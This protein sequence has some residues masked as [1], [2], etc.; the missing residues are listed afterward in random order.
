MISQTKLIKTIISVAGLLFLII[1]LFPYEA[2]AVYISNY[3]TDVLCILLIGILLGHYIKTYTLNYFDPLILITFIYTFMFFITPAYDIV[4][5][6]YTWFGYSMFQYGVKSGILALAGYLFFYFFYVSKLTN[7]EKR[8]TRNEQKD[9]EEIHDEGKRKMYMV[10]IVIFYVFSFLA[11]VYYLVHSGYAN[12]VYILTLGILGRGGSYGEVMESIG[13]IAMFSYCLPTLVL[14]YWEYAKNKTTTFLLFIPMLMLQV[15][16]GFRFLVVQIAISF[17]AYFFL[18]KNKQ[19]R[20]GQIVALIAV[21]MIPVIVMTIYRND[22]RNGI[23][24]S[25]FTMSFGVINEAIDSAIWDN[26]RIYNNYYGL[27][28]SVPKYFDYIYGRQMIIGTAAMA[29]PRAIWAGKIM[30][31]AGVDLSSI[32]GMRL[33][34]T[35]QAYP[36]LG[37]YYYSFGVPGVLFFMSLYGAWMRLVRDRYMKPSVKGYQCVMFC[38]LLGAN[39]QLLIRGYTPSNFWYIV[40]SLVPVFMIFCLERIYIK[41]VN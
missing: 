8:L 27:V 15:T 31:K 37:E 35:G 29:I 20:I 4:T 32:V 21:L 28:N 22:V 36:G 25:D 14:L 26:F 12:I 19:P 38:V 10:F 11:N 23:G 18:K 1:V 30:T 13:Y 40:F 16:R 39:L 41:K 17:A 7:F 34:K 33:A 9:K 24:I 2:E 3:V 6:Q 5:R